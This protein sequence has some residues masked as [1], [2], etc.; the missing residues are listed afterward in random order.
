MSPGSPYF[1]AYGGSLS[2][3]THT[4]F[5]VKCRFNEKFA[6]HSLLLLLVAPN[7]SVCS[8]GSVTSHA[9]FSDALAPSPSSIMP[10]SSSL[11]QT[12]PSSTSSFPGH[13]PW[14]LLWLADHLLTLT[15][16]G[17]HW[18]SASP[19]FMYDWMWTVHT[20][21]AILSEASSLTVSVPTV[22]LSIL[23]SLNASQKFMGLHFRVSPN[24]SQSIC[25]PILPMNP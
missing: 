16:L 24:L 10:C 23:E 20:P 13:Q 1:V 7:I 18:L 8:P 2:H 15:F 3:H 12:I 19:W 22:F 5:F 6:L 17:P 14:K 11:A 21:R 9:V 25:H 4:N